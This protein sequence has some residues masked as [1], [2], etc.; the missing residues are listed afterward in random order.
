MLQNQVS[1]GI[2]AS[3][4]MIA[5]QDVVARSR[6]AADKKEAFMYKLLFLPNSGHDNV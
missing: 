1:N 5:L 6:Y 2:Y 4:D 3:S